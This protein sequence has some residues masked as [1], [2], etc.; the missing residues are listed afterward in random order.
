MI[1]VRLFL[2][3]RKAIY[4]RG[5]YLPNKL[6]QRLLTRQLIKDALILYL[7]LRHLEMVLFD[8]ISVERIH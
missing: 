8:L 4:R 2:E 6:N 7:L 5:F 3:F 1:L